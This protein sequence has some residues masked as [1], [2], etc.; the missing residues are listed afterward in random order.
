MLSRRSFLTATA[1]GLP[2]FLRASS[3]SGNNLPEAFAQLERSNGGRL[4]VAVLDSATGVRTGYRADERFPMC[5][6]FKFL[7]VAAVL[8]RVDRHQEK[9]N[10]ALAIPP[11]PLIGNS[12]LTEPHAGATMTVAALCAAAL[13]RSDN[14]AA[15]LLLTTIGGPAGLTS[16]CRSIG[17]NV[18]RLDRTETSLNQA[19][20]GD[21]RD[22][23]SPEAM[24]NDLNKILLGDVLSHAARGQLTVWME[25][26]QTGLDKLRVT[27]PEGWRAADKTGNNGEN[28]MN[29]IAVFWPA[30]RKPIIVAAYITQCS[31]P[32][33]KRVAMLKQIGELVVRV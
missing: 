20:P 13:T 19:L 26:N 11:K 25:A 10:R 29:D 6:T 24:V 3:K 5:S 30:G 21:P 31:G 28:T 12:P 14:T 32:D 18:T 9:L 17:D 8:Q 33:S 2:A 1:I 27:L 4:G 15:N 7:L 23:S 16:F 22:T